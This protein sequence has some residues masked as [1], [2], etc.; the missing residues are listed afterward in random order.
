QCNAELATATK[1]RL[2][3]STNAATFDRHRRGSDCATAPLADK[4]RFITHVYYIANNNEAGDGV[5]TLKRAELRNGSFTTITPLAEGIEQ[6]ELEYGIDTS[7][8]GAP[9]GSY[10]SSPADPGEWAN[11]MAVEINLLARSTDPSPGHVD[12]KTYVLGADSFTPAGSYKR[13]VFQTT[14]RLSNPAGLRQQ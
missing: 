3:T 8:D 6:L 10:S 14:V 11:V 7:G 1:Y 12:S 5:P 2:S 4:R 9:D 13:H